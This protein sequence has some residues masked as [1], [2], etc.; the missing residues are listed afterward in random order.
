MIPVNRDTMMTIAT[1]AC[2]V[3]IIFLF[4]EMNKTKKEME[5]FRNFSEQVVKRITP[6]PRQTEPEPEPEVTEEVKSVE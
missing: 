4:K 2:A 5:T 6:P 3:G 1:I